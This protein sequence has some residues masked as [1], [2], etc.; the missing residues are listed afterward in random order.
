MLFCVPLLLLA[1]V[2]SSPLFFNGILMS[3]YWYMYAILNASCILTHSVK[4]IS[5]VEGLVYSQQCPCLIVHCLSSSLIHI[6]E[7]LPCLIFQV[8]HLSIFLSCSIVH[9]L[10]SCLVYFFWVSSLFHF[11]E[12]SIMI[13]FWNPVVHFFGVLV[14]FKKVPEFLEERLLSYLFFWFDFCCRF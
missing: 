8:R 1:A 9:F 5:R 11:S 2:I 13:F 7:F 4:V 12:S 3:M 10:P 6:S 14:Q